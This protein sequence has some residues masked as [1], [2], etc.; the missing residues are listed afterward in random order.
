MSVVAEFLVGTEDFALPAAAAMVDG[1]RIVAKG[2]PALSASQLTPF[3]AVS[4]VDFTA[5]EVALIADDTVESAD[6]CS[7]GDERHLYR[8]TWSDLDDS[9]CRV[10][11]SAD[12]TLTRAVYADG[13]WELRVHFPSR[14]A[15]RRFHERC[16]GRFSVTLDRVA[17]AGDARPDADETVTIAQREA[18]VTALERGYFDVP[19]DA[20]QEDLADELGISSQSVSQRLRRGQR[21]LLANAVH[22][23]FEL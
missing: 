13:R 18:L 15:L 21:N 2:V 17:E 12:A 3:L 20:T 5:F 9:L 1:G 10:L 22:S 6:R 16:R 19:R 14:E 23:R 8:V 11:G 7:A 4:G